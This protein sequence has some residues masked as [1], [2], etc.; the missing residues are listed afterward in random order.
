MALLFSLKLEE[1]PSTIGDTLSFP[2]HHI[3][4]DVACEK[5]L[6]ISTAGRTFCSP[7]EDLRRVGEKSSRGMA[8]I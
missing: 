4:Q 7:R 6:I 8:L 2:R 1:P 5:A 3:H